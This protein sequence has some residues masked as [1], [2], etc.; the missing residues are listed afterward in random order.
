MSNPLSPGELLQQFEKQIARFDPARGVPFTPNGRLQVVFKDAL[1]PFMPNEF[2]GAKLGEAGTE[3]GDRAKFGAV[4]AVP[5]SV[6]ADLRAVLAEQR[7]ALG[8]EKRVNDVLTDDPIRGAVNIR[9]KIPVLV[10]QSLWMPDVEHMAVIVEGKR[11]TA[12]EALQLINDRKD[13]QWDAICDISAVVKG[14]KAF[15]QITVIGLKAKKAN[16]DLG[17]FGS[18]G[19]TSNAAA[20]AAE[21]LLA[22][23]E[24]PKKRTKK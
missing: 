19:G 14:A 10:E 3:D 21:W 12:E 24:P 16:G 17:G 22:A 23:E 5:L 8:A 18:G 15:P 1:L 13:Y 9:V 20:A 4:L 7:A 6:G 11:A 2:E